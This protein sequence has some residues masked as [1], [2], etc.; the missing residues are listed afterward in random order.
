MEESAT[1]Q[2]VSA[3]AVDQSLNG[4]PTPTTDQATG[5]DESANDSTVENK[6]ESFTDPSQL[7]E[8]LQTIYKSMQ[9]DYTR[10]TQELSSFRTKAEQLD[11]LM[12]NPRFNQVLENLSGEA[13]KTQAPELDISQMSGEDVL[14]KI[15]EDPS[16]LAKMVR[17]EAQALVKPVSDSYYQ[18]KAE[19]EISRLRSAYPDFKEYESDIATMVEK[20]GYDPEDAYKTLTWGKM[21]QAG[22]NEGVKSVEQ[23][24]EAAQPD[25]THAAVTGNKAK[26]VF[27]AFE[28]AKKIHNWNG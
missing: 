13:T 26:T 3:P 9:G 24:K 12:S 1:S 4:N 5:T 21:K 16:F 23:R 10:K 20:R 19:A 2:A 15:V 14:T 7:P 6:E 28:H 18:D 22:I 25:T 8:E 17:Q 11:A 27:E